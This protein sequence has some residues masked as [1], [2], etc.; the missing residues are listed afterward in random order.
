M[1]WALKSSSR[2]RRDVMM[3]EIQSVRGSCPLLWAL[4]ME[5]AGHDPRNAGGLWKREMA[6][7]WQPA[8]K[9]GLSPM[10]AR[11]WI[12]ATTWMST[13]FS[14]RAS[15]KDC[16]PGDTLIQS[17]E[18]HLGLL[19][20]TTARN[21]L[22]LF[23]PPRLQTFVTAATEN[24]YMKKRKEKKTSTWT[25]LCPHKSINSVSPGMS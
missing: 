3:E 11:K 21:K 7:S 2:S 24:K 23:K 5:K 10:S 17:I 14:P 15:R 9:Q 13:P 1:T 25:K 22:M 16:G 19:T 4:K 20:N 18:V 8:R 12:L 6:L